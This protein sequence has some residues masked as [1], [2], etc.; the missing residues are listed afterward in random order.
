MR[1]RRYHRHAVL[2]LHETSHV[3]Q[4]RFVLGLRY[5]SSNDILDVFFASER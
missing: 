4:C 3:T 5:R 2:A 1:P